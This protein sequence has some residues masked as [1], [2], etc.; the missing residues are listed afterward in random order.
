LLITT[1]NALPGDLVPAF[2]AP[3]RGRRVAI[4]HARDVIAR[5]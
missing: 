4:W 5:G 2:T 3:Y 1:P